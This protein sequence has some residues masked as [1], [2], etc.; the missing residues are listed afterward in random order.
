MLG[1]VIYSACAMV[2]HRVGVRVEV[3]VPA[4][5][6]A[7]SFQIGPTNSMAERVSFL[8]LDVLKVYAIV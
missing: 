4:K 6:S 7:R 2:L 3:I 1:K 8:P 5:A